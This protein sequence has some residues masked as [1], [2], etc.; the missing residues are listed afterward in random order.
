MTDRG[1]PVAML[2]PVVEDPWQ[3]LVASGWVTPPA[4]EG[5]IL[6]EGPADYGIQ[7]SERL[8]AMRAEER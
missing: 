3:G 6:D 5:D 2:V 4:G 1:R 7:A 8:V